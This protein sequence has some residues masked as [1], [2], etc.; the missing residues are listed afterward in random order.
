[1]RIWEKITRAFRLSKGTT[2]T[3][4]IQAKPSTTSV[5]I[6]ESSSEKPSYSSDQ[7][8]RSKGEDRFNRWPFAER[9]ADT[10]ARRKDSAGLVVAI[11]GV[12]GD[13]K[14]SVLNL[15]EQALK[16]HEDVVVIRFNPWLF[17]SLPKLLQGFFTTLAEAL[18][19]SLPTK[20]EELGSIL[21]RYGAI[22][23]VASL[24]IGSGIQLSPGTAIQELGQSLSAT[25]LDDLK[26]RME[27]ILNI[28]N[29]KLAVLI[30]DIDRLDRQ[31]IH[32]V[33][34]LVKLSAGFE[35][36][37]YILAFD[38]DVVTASL[39]EAYAEGDKQ[40]GR[41][42]LEKI[43][44]VPLHLPPGDQL[45]LRKLAFEGAESALTLAGVQLSQEQIDAFVRHFVDGLELALVTPRHAK[46]YSNALAF[47]LPILKGEVHPVDQMLVEGIRVFYP[48]L[49]NSIRENPD[50]FLCSNRTM[51][52]QDSLRQRATEIIDGALSEIH[53]EDRERIRRGLL[54]VLFPQLK[55]IFGNVS[56]GSGSLEKWDKE[57]R[58]CSQDYFDRYFRYS[59]PQ[60]DV[61]DLSVARLLE[62]SERGDMEADSIFGSIADRGGMARL[63][64]KLRFSEEKV[65]RSAAEHLALLVARH[66]G[67]VPRERGPFISD[68]S[69]R[70]A[71]ILVSKLL[72]RVP[73]GSE[74]ENLA[75]RL[76][77]E[78][79]P[80]PFAGECLGWFRKDQ[81]A[82]ESDRILPASVEDEIGRMLADRIRAHASQVPLYRQFPGDANYLFLVWNKYG[83][84]GEV[85]DYLL[86]R[87]ES[88]LDEVDEFLSS[89]VGTAWGIESGLSHKSDFMRDTYDTISKVFD[90]EFL[91][92]KLR[93]HY[94][95][96]LDKPDYYEHRGGELGRRIAHQFAFVH[97]SVKEEMQKKAKEEGGTASN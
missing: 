96:E 94:G 55:G 56:Y 31:E 19:K 54:E 25:E 5:T 79:E 33:F 28:T 90:P 77:R 73:A 37:S 50:I 66:G 82:P 85:R 48:R 95:P 15:L 3:V 22:L 62:A 80:L 75:R 67:S 70:Q 76:I 92:Q 17:E 29:K 74:R 11:Y 23:S 59:V 51:T 64:P 4:P 43:V 87:F 13:G 41:N 32:A 83:V 27:G 81:K 10:L 1:M 61:S 65:G 45:E 57:Q 24:D 86:D 34:K 97:L 12:W 53:A 58:V 6:E 89:C 63:I 40:A 44:Q 20:V 30:D 93:T 35:R 72:L 2:R 18:G 14:T 7:P 38:Y 42:F 91:F 8:I 60:G 21:R 49:Y 36:T 47:A 84:E 39:G 26:K 9:I 71:A 78:A 88:N 69:F 16:E 68:I 46:R 52:R